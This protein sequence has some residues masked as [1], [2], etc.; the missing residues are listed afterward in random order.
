MS[1]N[2]LI[3]GAYGYTGRLVAAEAKRRGMAPVLAGRREKPLAHLAKELGL[4]Y[5]VIDLDDANALA[6]W[7]SEHRVVLHCAGPFSSTAQPMIEACLA[8]ET[9]YLDITGEISV[10][11][12]AHEQNDRAAAEGVALVPGVGFDVVPTDCL[13][14]SLKERLPDASSLTLA[15]DA[16]GGPSRGTAKSALEGFAGGGFIRQDGELVPVP[17][18]FKVKEIPFPHRRRQAVTIPW[19]D[20]YTAYVTTGIPNIEVYY[21]ISPR[22]VR[23]IRRMRYLRPLIALAPVQKFLKSRIDRTLDPP[24]EATRAKSRCYVWGE[25]RDGDGSRVRGRMI[26]PNGYDVTVQASLRIV[27]HFFRNPSIDGGYYTPAGLMGSAYAASLPGV[28]V[29]ID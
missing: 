29:E 12:W 25:V 20:V 2:W 15:F 17:V 5:A 11:Q 28:S 13:A 9:H 24:D 3:Y 23:R 10:F 8:S 18:G 1:T 6:G 16:E 26:T 27:D 7:L 22:T 21:A 14:L 4:D 19:G